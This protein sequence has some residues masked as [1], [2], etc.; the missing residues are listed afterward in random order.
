MNRMPNRWLSVIWLVA[1]TAAGCMDSP[2][3]P[4][5]RAA[6]P[7]AVRTEMIKDHEVVRPGRGFTLGIELTIP[8]GR[9]IHWQDPGDGGEPTRVRLDLPEGCRAGR[10]RWPL[11]ERLETPDG[12]VRFGYRDKTLLMVPI[13]AD[14]SWQIGDRIEWS[15]TVSWQSCPRP[16]RKVRKALKG[17]IEVGY[18]T[19]SSEEARFRSWRDKIPSGPLDAGHLIDSTSVESLG[20]GRRRLGVDWKKP[21]SEVRLFPV[22]PKGLAFKVLN[23]VHEGRRSVVHY[24]VSK[25]GPKDRLK[26]FL[27]VLATCRLEDGRRNGGWVMLPVADGG[28]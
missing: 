4:A 10:I 22:V 23:L 25:T 28:R 27:R 12:S 11:P 5:P 21:V 9:W 8:P 3:P 14:G 15:A 7:S 24:A 2:H 17:D 1:F 6:P 19:P 13:V 20:D 16:C 18:T 26:P